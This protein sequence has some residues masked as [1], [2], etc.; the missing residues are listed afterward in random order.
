MKIMH[1]GDLHIGR[2]INQHSLIEDQRFMLNQLLDEMDDKKVEAV[3]IAGDLFDVAA[4][5]GEAVKLVDEFMREINIK[6]QLPIFAV[7]GNHDGVERLIYG[8]DWYKGH[9]LHMHTSIN[10]AIEPITFKDVNFYLIPY[11]EPVEAR[12]HFEDEAIRT[13][14][15]T[16][17]AIIDSIIPQ[18]DNTQK[19]IVISHLF[20]QGGKETDSERP[21][22]MGAIEYVPQSLFSVFDHVALGHLHHPFA[23]NSET[24]FY[25]GSLLKYSFSESEQPKG[26][27]LITIEDEIKSHFVPLKPLRDLKEIDVDYIEAVND[28]LNL[29]S[30]DDYL[31]MNLT[32][33]AGHND[34]MSKL[35]LIYPN[36]LEIRPA[37]QKRERETKLTKLNL[38][39]DIDIIKQF[40]L[41]ESDEKLSVEQ[42]EILEQLMKEIENEAH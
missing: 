31:K 21:I 19:N 35:K 2:R 28:R 36:L 1:I 11:I 29:L 22:S 40:V 12:I 26:Y 4:P 33:L 24:I 32:N 39:N 10:E 8:S 41:E 23:I 34:P 6:R 9:Q 14:E 38:K 7:S 37:E 15:D 13:H 16:Y 25:S 17:Q 27:R 5:S 20:V 18:M 42:E 30:N 3:I